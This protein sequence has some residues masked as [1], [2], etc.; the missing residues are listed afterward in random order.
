MLTRKI[1]ATL[2]ENVDEKMQ[3]ILPKNVDNTSEKC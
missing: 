1:L 3:T 2:P